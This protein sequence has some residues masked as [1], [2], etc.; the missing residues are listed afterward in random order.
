M[1]CIAQK[2]LQNKKMKCSDVLLDIMSGLQ[3]DYNI[4]HYTN[5]ETFKGEMN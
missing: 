1:Y 5:F 2:L 4:I 3:V